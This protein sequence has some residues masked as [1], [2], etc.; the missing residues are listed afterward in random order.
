MMNQSGHE[1]AIEDFLRRPRP[2]RL[3]CGVQHYA[4]GDASYLPNL[5]GVSNRDRKPYAELWIGAHP[6]LP[7]VAKVGDRALPLPALFNGAAEVVL[8]REDAESGL[9]VYE[10]PS[11]E[12]RLCRL[13]LASEGTHDRA[14]DHGLDL[15]VVTGGRAVITA[16]KGDGLN[17]KP[18]D[19]FLAPRGLGYRVSS[20]AGAEIFTASIPGG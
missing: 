20:D 3:S 17:L 18:G 12:F 11:T 19:T 10:T 6:E 16:A 4:W 15:G 1:L 14:D 9:D 5:L 7:S 13:N 2:L 8:G